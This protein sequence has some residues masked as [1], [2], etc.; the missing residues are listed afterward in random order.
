MLAERFAN[1]EKTRED[2]VKRLSDSIYEK[3]E[4]MKGDIEKERMACEESLSVIRD[5]I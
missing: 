4:Q 5:S 1:L 3:E 2:A